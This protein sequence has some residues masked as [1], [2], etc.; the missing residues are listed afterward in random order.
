MEARAAAR[1]AVI[2]TLPGAEH[3]ADGDGGSGLEA[4]ADDEELDEYSQGCA[5]ELGGGGAGGVGNCPRPNREPE[6]D[7]EP[8]EG[9]AEV[10]GWGEA[11]AET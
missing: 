6:E 1:A 2:P 10:G 4:E 5:N 7:E 9:P 3:D 11:G 8:V